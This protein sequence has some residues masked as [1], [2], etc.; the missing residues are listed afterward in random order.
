M[1]FHYI[2][3]LPILKQEDYHYVQRSTAK[4]RLLAGGGTADDSAAEAWTAGTLSL[5]FL[6][7][8][9]SFPVGALGILFALLSRK[10]D[11]MDP[12]AKLGC[13][14]SIIGLCLGI[15]IFIYAAVTVYQNFPELIQ[16]YQQLY[17]MSQGG[18]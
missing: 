6:V 5:F 13:I 2:T 8:G 14:L 12:Q 11:K 3:I 7:S 15:A 16:Q 9:L 18:M 17:E 4:S 10:G 1:F